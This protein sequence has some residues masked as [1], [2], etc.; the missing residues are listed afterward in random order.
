MLNYSFPSWPAR[1]AVL[2]TLLLIGAVFLIYGPSLHGTWI[3]DD[4]WYLPDNPLI[5]DQNRLWKAW[6]APGS[7]VEFYPI[8]ESVQWIQWQL[9]H[10]DTLGYHLTNVVLHIVSVLLVWRLLGKFG[11]RFAWLGALLFAVHPETVDSVS[12]I[13]ELKNTLSLPPYLV[14]MCLYIDFDEN[15][16]RRCYLWA[17]TSF[18]IAMLC[19]ITAAPFPLLI[20][21]YAWWKRGRIGWS[22]VKVSV[23]FFVISLALGMTTIW[24]GEI[25]SHQF[26]HG[27]SAPDAGPLGGF[28]FRLALAGQIVA[29]YFSRSFLP[30]NPMPI[31]PKWAVDPSHWMQFTPWLILGLTVLWLWSKRRT[32]GRHALFGLGFF[33]F[34][35]SPFLGF[36]A[37]S[38]MEATWILDHMLYIPIIGLVGLVAAGWEGMNAQLA[39]PARRWS[40][41]ILAV[42]VALLIFQSNHYASQ[43][44]SEESLARYN[45]QFNSENAGLH[46]DLGAGLAVRGAYPEAIEQFRIAL[47]IDPHFTKAQSNL[48]NALLDMEQYPE[49]IAAYKQALVDDPDKGGVREKLADT[50]L[51]THRIP[52]AIDQ[53]QQVILRHEDTALTHINL[54]TA[55]F[56]KGNT[57]E[58]IQQ[59][60]QAIAL[61]PNSALAQYNLAKALCLTGHETDGVE[62]YRR[63]I[64]L[65]PDFAQAH[66]NLGIVLFREGKVLEA[67]EEFQR[68]LKARAAFP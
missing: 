42:I 5:H 34:S 33:V 12:E 53:Y 20:L 21:L 31:Y 15:K 14:A 17:L 35:L 6:F 16:S 11:L 19:K 36:H 4:F 61:D 26:Q 66:N 67:R 3:G 62:A 10:S 59:F 52:E 24:A 25:Y 9:W 13:V 68:A 18:L 45:L 40:A 7:W 46:N 44:M 2:K 43:F 55:L 30:I 38:Y 64:K 37:I 1:S 32:W 41:G 29:F 48:G 63:A 22:D 60:K 54:G 23:P 47:R 27:A 50:F 39:A 8:E 56:M 51:Q 28:F 57:G 58:G 49:A 65:Q